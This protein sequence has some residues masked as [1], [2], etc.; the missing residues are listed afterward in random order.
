MWLL[1]PFSNLEWYVLFKTKYSAFMPTEHT[2]V[3]SHLPVT[4]ASNFKL[5]INTNMST[6]SF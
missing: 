5:P 2:P 6:E 4:A 3:T 1:V